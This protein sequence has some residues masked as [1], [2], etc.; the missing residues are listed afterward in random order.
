MACNLYSEQHIYESYTIGYD[1]AMAACISDPA[2]CDL[3]SL[4]Q[5]TELEEQAFQAGKDEGYG[6]GHTDGYGSGYDSGYSDGLTAGIA[7][8][9]EQGIEQGIEQG[10]GDGFE[11]GLAEGIEQGHEQGLAEGLEQ[12]IEQGSNDTLALCQQTPEECG[13][14]IGAQPAD[15]LAVIQAIRNNLPNGQVVSQCKKG[16]SSPLCWDSVEDVQL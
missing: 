6:E 4:V 1:D 8:G 5:V 2:S 12:G 3:F 15:I 13:I 11:Q 7:E 10:F 14:E 9:L 16:G